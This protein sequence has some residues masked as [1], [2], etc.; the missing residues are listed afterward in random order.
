MSFTAAS[1]NVRVRLAS[2][3]GASVSM[4]SAGGEVT[5]DFPVEVRTDPHSGHRSARGEI[6][7]GGP[8]LRLSSASGA[9]SLDRL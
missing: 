6:G 5:T 8:R 9:V 1:G 4:S 2:H 3:L 7:G